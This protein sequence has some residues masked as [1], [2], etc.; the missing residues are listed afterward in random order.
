MPESM[1]RLNVENVVFM[2]LPGAQTETE[3]LLAWSADNQS[4][5]LQGFLDLQA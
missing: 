5:T 1:N 4:L 2:E 3:I